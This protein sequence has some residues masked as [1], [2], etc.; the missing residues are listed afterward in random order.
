MFIYRTIKFTDHITQLQRNIPHNNDSCENFIKYDEQQKKTFYFIIR[1]QNK[2]KRKKE[3]FYYPK[4]YT[5]Y[6][7]N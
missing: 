2:E 6:T 7:L 3:N 5:Q 4:I 1:I